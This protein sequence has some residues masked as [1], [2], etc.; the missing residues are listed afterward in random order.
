[1]T[2]M[3][4]VGLFEY[5][6]V[7]Q[8]AQQYSVAAC[9]RFMITMHGKWIKESVNR[10]QCAAMQLPD[11]LSSLASKSLE[12]GVVKQVGTKR[13]KFRERP[14]I[15]ILHVHYQVIGGN[16]RGSMVRAAVHYCE[17]TNLNDANNMPVFKCT[18]KCSGFND[19]Y[20]WYAG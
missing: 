2:R 6:S 17:L 5:N 14:G 7:Q 16:D 11:S 1:M 4:G 20:N 13:N 12:G 18:V 9:H 3:T 19:L 15:A 8:D 10:S